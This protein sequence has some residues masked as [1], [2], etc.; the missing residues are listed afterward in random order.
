M[1]N[2]PQLRSPPSWWQSRGRVMAQASL[3][4]CPASNTLPC[5]RQKQ[6]PREEQQLLLALLS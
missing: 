2:E 4:A 5:R 1:S 6:F 3:E